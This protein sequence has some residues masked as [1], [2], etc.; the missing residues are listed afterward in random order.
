[1]KKNPLTLYRFIWLIMLIMPCP[2]LAADAHV[3]GKAALQLAIDGNRLQINLQS[4]LETL[5][6]FEHMPRTPQQKTAVK[7]M[8]NALRQAER[9]FRPTPAAACRLQSVALDSAVLG[10]DKHPA[11][12]HQAHADLDG[13]FVFSCGR[14]DALRDLEVNL[15]DAFPGLRELKAEAVTPRGQ[16]AATLTSGQRRIGW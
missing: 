3:H 8:E 9:L 4:P 10:Q 5:L 13:E 7:A 11:H 2:V 12:P 14:V 1:M 16:T 6:G 15:F